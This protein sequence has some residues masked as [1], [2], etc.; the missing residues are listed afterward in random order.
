LKKENKVAS[1]LKIYGVINAVT[2]IILG[3]VLSNNLPYSLEFLWI[4][5]VAVGIVASFL[6]YAFGEVVQI[7]HDIRSN[8]SS[9][10]KA[11]EY[12]DDELPDL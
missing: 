12:L 5:E 1:I 6:L 9:P 4:V 2:C 8:T 11:K 10:D 7:L 3:A